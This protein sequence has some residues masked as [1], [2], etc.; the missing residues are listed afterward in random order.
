MSVVQLR[1]TH[2]VKKFIPARQ[3]KFVAFA[4]V[5]SFATIGGIIALFLTNAASLTIDPSVPSPTNV[6][7]YGDDRNVIVTWNGVNSSSIVGYYLRWKKV[8]A[9]NWEGVKQTTHTVTQLQPLDNNQQYEIEVH[10]VRGTY[11]VYEN[12]SL[13]GF[14]PA[15][16]NRRSRFARA[17]GHVSQPARATATT[18]SARVDA[19]RQRLTGF[20]DDFNVPSNPVDELKWNMA[21]SGCTS[22]GN[23]GSFINT[24]FHT[25][26]MVKSGWCDRAG[27]IMRP[28]AIFNTTGATES[29]PAQIEFDMDGITN[30][31]RDLW[32]MDI[33]PIDARTDNLTLDQTSHDGD[34][35]FPMNMIRLNQG[36]STASLQYFPAGNPG[37]AQQL[38]MLNNTTCQ[39]P[40]APTDWPGPDVSA[41][42]DCKMNTRTTTEFSPLPQQS[43]SIMPVANVRRHWVIQ[44]TPTRMRIFVDGYK[45]GD[46]AL[47]AAFA[48]K[49][50]FVLHNTVFSYNTGKAYDTTKAFPST[51]MYHWDNF[52]FTGPAS[53][54][55]VHNY[56]EGGP[57]GNTPGI[58]RSLGTGQIPYEQRTTNIKVP[59]EIGNIVGGRARLMFSIQNFGFQSYSYTPG[60]HIIFNGKRY[61]FAD[62]AN[63]MP[64]YAARSVIANPISPANAVIYIDRAD[65]RRGDNMVTFNIGGGIMN[66]HLELPYARTDTNR[67]SY[68]QPINIYGQTLSNLV[69]PPMTNCDSYNYV[70]QDLDLPY[71][72]SKANLTVGTCAYLTH[73]VQH[74]PGSTG[75]QTPLPNPDTTLPTVLLT[76]PANNTTA[77][78]G[79]FTASANAADNVGVGKVD[80]Y[81]GGQIQSSDTSSP[82]SATISTSGLAPGTY[83]VFAQAF[84]TTNNMT[85]SSS[86][87]IVIPQPADTTRPTVSLTAPANNAS[88]TSGSTLTVSANASDAG[89]IARVDFYIDNE[90]K[91]SDTSS[92]YSQS[93]V[94]TGINPGNHTVFARAYDAAGNTQDSASVTFTIP[95][96]PPTS[97]PAGQ[98]GTPPNCTVPELTPTPDPVPTPN[99]APGKT[100]DLNGDGRVNF[101]D[102]RILLGNY[103]KS[104]TANTSGDLNGDSRVN[105]TDLRILLGNYG[106]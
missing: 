99:P 31:E 10:S 45:I 67:P 49:R 61:D 95:T 43:Q 6:Q 3:R 39:A 27:V 71:L 19:M 48:S 75:S 92:L 14:W 11:S 40:E 29:N 105:F 96:P 76:A 72:G 5:M 38:T 86:V 69:E 28:R 15:E 37:G 9:S 51:A 81:L 54:E 85:Q 36:A 12:G 64:G 1:G 50:Q 42:W 100:G 47:P 78:S 91:A 33:V 84:D 46:T 57:N 93:V 102:L 59:D 98:T 18:S 74:N 89:G 52:G 8:G 83:A 22:P 87:N 80:F 103:N 79:S 17:D 66:V 24:Q 82:Y 70:E 53:S 94:M 7:A 88:V 60:E 34:Y 13:D 104:V 32:Y 23:V 41:F 35:S 25:H 77:S 90:L 73:L 101:T 30:P 65:I 56:I 68:T 58:G 2:K 4:F 20:F 97:C 44:I 21:A 62:Q 106:K 16:P 26:N 63:F 55:I